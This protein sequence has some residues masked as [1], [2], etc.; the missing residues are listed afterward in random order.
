MYTPDRHALLCCRPVALFLAV[1]V[2]RG[3]ARLTRTKKSTPRCAA[4]V[5]RGKVYNSKVYNSKVYKGKVYNS[6][7]Y[8]S[9]P[10][11]VIASPLILCRD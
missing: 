8:N 3:S 5:K 10:T 9:Q 7:G 4:S 2:A 6:K 11:G 1:V